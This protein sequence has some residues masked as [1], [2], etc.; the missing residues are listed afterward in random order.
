MKKS[1]FTKRII[2]AVL[3]ISTA[4]T[5]ISAT[6]ITASAFDTSYISEDGMKLGY[7]IING[8]SKLSAKNGLTSYKKSAIYTG[9]DV[10]NPYVITLVGIFYITNGVDFDKAMNDNDYTINIISK[11]DGFLTSM[12]VTNEKAKNFRA[13]L[14]NSDA[15]IL[16]AFDTAGLYIIEAN[17]DYCKSLINNENVDFVL[18]DGCIPKSMKDLNYD[19]KSDENDAIYIQ[20]YLAKSL[21]Y[22]DHDE[23]E[24]L[25]FACDINGDKELNILDVTELQSK[26]AG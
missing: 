14:Q 18:S 11:L 2:S 15:K 25:K 7:S 4:F 10:S 6:T 19:G 13:E 9:L 16:T 17:E 26:K 3:T 1:K 24:Y 5:A 20:E 8:Y 21:S 22:S 12:G 23:M